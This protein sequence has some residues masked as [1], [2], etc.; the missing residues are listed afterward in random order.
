M[1]DSAAPAHTL[2]ISEIQNLLEEYC[3]GQQ[4]RR[5]PFDGRK[6]AVLDPTDLER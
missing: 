5:E 2:T 6:A 4:N 1:D 3:R